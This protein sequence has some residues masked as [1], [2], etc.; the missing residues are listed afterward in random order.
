M[1]RQFEALQM[2]SRRKACRVDR[3]GRPVD[4]VPEDVSCRC[5]QNGVDHKRDRQLGVGLRDDRCEPIPQDDAVALRP[6]PCASLHETMGGGQIRGH[7]GPVGEL[8]WGW[9]W[10]PLQG[11]GWINGAAGGEQGRCG[12]PLGPAAHDVTVIKPSF[13]GLWVF[14]K[15]EQ[16]AEW[17]NESGIPKG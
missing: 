8:A 14:V 11:C 15:P 12:C 4:L 16:P 9:G 6:A 5:S 2:S 3:S 13:V 1:V 10:L 7:T 17:F